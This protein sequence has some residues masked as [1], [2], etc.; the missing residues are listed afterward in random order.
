MGELGRGRGPV[1]LGQVRGVGN[2]EVEAGKPGRAASPV[3]G[4]EKPQAAGVLLGEGEGL[5]ARVGG[6]HL[7]VGASVLDGEGDGP[8][9][10]PHVQNPGGTPG[11]DRFQGERHQ[12]LGLGAGEEDPGPYLELE[13][14]KLHLAQDQSEG[15]AAPAADEPVLEA[16]Q[17][18]FGNGFSQAGE[19]ALGGLCQGGLGQRPGLGLGG[20]DPR[21]PE[22]RPQPGEELSSAL[23]RRSHR[24][25]GRRRRGGHPPPP[26]TRCR[27]PGGL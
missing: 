27:R 23:P 19:K 2:E 6:V 1:G 21:L 16:D 5:W 11:R 7:G 24:R 20:R 18:A 14:E 26:R 3:E 9:P 22:L 12:A 4:D 17:G 25:R 15:L 10:R 13:P 8:A